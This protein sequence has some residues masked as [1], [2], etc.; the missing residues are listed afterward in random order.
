MEKRILVYNNRTGIAEK[1]IFLCREEGFAVTVAADMPQLYDAL[2]KTEIHLLLV[3]VELEDKGWDKGMEM[4]MDLRSR[5]RVPLI[6]V[7]EQSSET[8][9]IMALSVGADDYVTADCNPLV[10]LARIKSHVRRY[11]QLTEMK[12]CAARIYRVEGLVVDDERKC[13]LVEGREVLLTPIEYDILRLLVKQKGRVFSTNQ[14]YESV[15]KMKE[16]FEDRTIMVHICH[17]RKKI[18]PNPKQPKYLKAVWGYG[19]KVG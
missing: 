13:V 2:E 7:T 1:V 3:D 8:A 12:S 9:K 11:T 6:V 19:Y 14:I 5:S 10:L 17:I 16:V 4:I 15:W 18:E